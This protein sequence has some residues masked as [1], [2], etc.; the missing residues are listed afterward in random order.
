MSKQMSESTCRYAV[1]HTPCP[2]GYI[3]WFGWAHRMS[4]TH[5][6]I[7]CEG[8]GLY[9]VWVTKMPREK[10]TRV[11]NAIEGVSHE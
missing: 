9:Y 11:S 10:K 1:S 4:K 3:A 6:Q 7:R 5:R 2:N 8:C